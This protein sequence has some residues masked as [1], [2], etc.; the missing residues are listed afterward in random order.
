VG[1]QAEG[2]VTMLEL[3]RPPAILDILEEHL[4]ELDFLWEQRERFVFSPDWTLKELAAH[5]E[6]AEAHLDGLRIGAANSVDIARPALTA[7]ETG[8]ATAATFVLM[9]FDHVEL[10]HE[11]LDA[12]K[13]APPKS[14]DGIR[15]GL[16]HC[17]IKRLAAELADMATTGESA[18]RAAALDV[19]AFHRLPP[20]KGIPMLL[21]DADP[22]VRRLVYDAAG[23]FGGPWSYDVL[24]DALDGDV[25]ALRTAALR[26][27]ARMGLLGLDD[28]CRLA[29]TR[30]QDPVPEALEFLGVLGNPKDLALLQNA[31]SRPELVGAALAGIGKLGSITPIPMLLESIANDMLAHAAGRAFVRI[32]GAKDI[33]A[34]KPLPP[35]EG[36]TEEEIQDWD[37]SLP[38]DPAKA[39]AWWEKE[40]ARFSAEGR[41]QAGFDVSKTPFEENFDAMPLDARLDVYLG[42]RA[43]DPQKTQ[44][45]ELAKRA[46]A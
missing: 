37:T 30:P 41:W 35:P 36:A 42:A 20:P 40:K 4:N 19:L 45:R 44:D 10:E 9:A 14:R 11:V 12:L 31:M 6:R 5:E 16:H 2:E 18:V 3:P 29:G 28:S 1:L 15:I 43:R 13:S 7:G 32:T 27:S 46:L 33:E 26:A 8:L 22:H 34:A 17:D 21:G 25:P 23:R 39:R 38:P 24:R